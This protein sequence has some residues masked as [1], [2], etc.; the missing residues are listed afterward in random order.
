MSTGG[1]F[2]MTAPL[3]V[4]CDLMQSRRR[5]PVK[6]QYAHHINW[7]EAGVHRPSVHILDSR[8]LPPCAR[9]GRR[10]TGE[11]TGWVLFDGS[12]P[13]AKGRPRDGIARS[14]ADPF[15]QF[16]DSS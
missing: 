5:P 16:V 10:W 7:P 8:L 2:G 12:K 6:A 4:E 15:G 11:R 1:G 14:N 13:D 3:C 9:L